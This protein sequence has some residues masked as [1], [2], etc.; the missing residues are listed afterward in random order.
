MS[1]RQAFAVFAAAILS[2][3]CGATP[4]IASPVV[5]VINFGSTFYDFDVGTQTATE[6]DQRTGSPFSSTLDTRG[7]GTLFGLQGND[8]IQFVFTP[9]G[10]TGEPVATLS[11][12]I[13]AIAFDGN[14]Q[15]FG[16]EDSAL[17]QIDPVT[18]VVSKVVDITHSGSSISSLTGFEI[19]S[20]GTHYAVDS[21]HL[22]TFDPV[23]GVATQAANQG[24]PAFSPIFTDLAI[25]PNG[26]LFATLFD[27]ETPIALVNPA[28]GLA[29][30]L[31]SNPAGAPYAAVA[32]LVPEP[33]SGLFL[34]AGLGALAAR[35]RVLRRQH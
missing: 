12:S 27:T 28:T 4:T 32:Y 8:L 29:T 33:T 6:V 9:L 30:R 22:Y 3:F 18:G 5:R 24:L 2:C 16:I 31:G 35:R 15:L 11:D 19:G 17:F 13:E 23:T 21:T 20:D 10:S 26:Q 25:A 7:D 1:N 34:I 14:D